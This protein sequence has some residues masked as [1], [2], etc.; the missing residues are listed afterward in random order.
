MGGLIR[1]L[2][3]L[4]VAAL[5]LLCT[6]CAGFVP[7]LLGDPR[8]DELARTTEALRGLEFERPYTARFVEREEI[9][10]LVGGMIDAASEPGYI[11]AYRDAYAA[12]GAWPPDLDLR[13]TVLELQMDQILGLYDPD[14]ETLYVVSD[15]GGEAFGAE[16]D[17]TIVHELVHALQHQ[18]FP[19]LF[20]IQQGLRHN[21]DLVTALAA[22]IEGDASLT[23]LANMAG[24]GRSVEMADQLAEVMLLDQRYPEGKLAEV[25]RLMRVSMLFGYTHGTPIAARSYAARGNAGLDALLEAPPLSTRQAREPGDDPEVEFVALPLEA[26]GAALEPRGCRIAHQNVAGVLTTGV[27]FE[28]WEEPQPAAGLAAL[29]RDWRG[30]RFVHVVCGDVWELAWL[31]R[32]RSEAAAQAFATRYQAI[33]PRIA[34]NAP[35]SGVPSIVQRGPAVLIRTDGL[36]AHDSLLLD[37]SEVRRYSSF[38]DWV[39]DDCFTESPCPRLKATPALASDAEDHPEIHP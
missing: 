28:D 21:D 18:H 11:V 13:Q 2:R 29:L 4:R 34:A 9:P 36:A 31:S 39:A 32:W 22:A 16:S 17:A 35:L 10:A 7:W 30:D 25:P 15:G 23:M 20:A 38:A 5:A 8:I 26:L 1:A 14:S 12:L 19:G 6:G 24:D 33:A 27:L 37:Q 3:P